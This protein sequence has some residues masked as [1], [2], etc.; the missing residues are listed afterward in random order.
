MLVSICEG[1]D[2]F[3]INQ[4]FLS[5]SPHKPVLTSSLASPGVSLPF[6]APLGAGEAGEQPSQGS[7]H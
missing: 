6:H 2:D 5:L 4:T 3:P 7:L 1:G